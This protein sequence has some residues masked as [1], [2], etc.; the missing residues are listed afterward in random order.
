METAFFTDR[1]EA[2]KWAALET[3]NVPMPDGSVRTLTDWK[4][5][6]RSYDIIIADGLFSASEIAGLALLTASE[7]S[8]S[9]ESSFSDVVSYIHGEIARADEKL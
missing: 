9:F 1:N 2:A 8:E 4:L 5:T 6:W 7:R 3:R